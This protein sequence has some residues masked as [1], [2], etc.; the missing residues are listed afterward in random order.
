MSPSFRNLS[1]EIPISETKLVIMPFGY[2]SPSANDFTF[3]CLPISLRMSQALY[4]L[5]NTF[6]FLL[7]IQGKFDHQ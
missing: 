3:T 4:L 1:L 2:V 7:H 6:Q 5:R